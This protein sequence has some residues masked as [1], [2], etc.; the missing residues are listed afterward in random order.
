M[1]G[2]ESLSASLSG[3]EVK[4]RS[5]G[6]TV[7]CYC[8]YLV[9]LGFGCRRY[10]E[11]KCERMGEVSICISISAPDNLTFH[12]SVYC[13]HQHNQG[14]L[15]LSPSTTH[16]ALYSHYYSSLDVRRTELRQDSAC[17]CHVFT[18]IRTTHQIVHVI[19][20][21]K[22][23]SCPHCTC[24]GQ[25]LKVGKL[26]KNTRHSCKWNVPHCT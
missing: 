13:P 17:P 11:E 8:T 19:K 23:G 2:T 16:P 25:Q 9:S 5:L 1:S 26:S 14:P 3:G 20:S 22:S 12:T 4:G 21:L 18:L 7:S 15:T 10:G 6:Y 24:K